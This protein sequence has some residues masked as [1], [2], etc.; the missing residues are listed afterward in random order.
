MEINMVMAKFMAMMIFTTFDG[1][2]S[3]TIVLNSARTVKITIR[4]MIAKMIPM[5]PDTRV[6]VRR[7]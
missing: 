1:R 4:L 6:P 2:K 5:M 7:E 3:N